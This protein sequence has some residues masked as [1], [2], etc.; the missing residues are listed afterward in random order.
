MGADVLVQV[1]YNKHNIY[2]TVSQ[3]PLNF[4][5]LGLGGWGGGGRARSCFSQQLI[6]KLFFVSLIRKI[7]NKSQITKFGV[8]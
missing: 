8:R 3:Q 5:L 1:T 7:A 2:Q 6:K 4:F